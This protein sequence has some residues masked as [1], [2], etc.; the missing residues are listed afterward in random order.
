MAIDAVSTGIGLFG[1][2]GADHAAGAAADDGCPECVSFADVLGAALAEMADDVVFADADD[3]LSDD[4]PVAA[5]MDTEW[6][7]APVDADPAVGAAAVGVDAAAATPKGGYDLD[8][9]FEAAAKKYNISAK[10]LKAVAK[11]E[12]NFRPDATSRKGAMGIMQLMPG[13]AAGLG[14][15]DGYDPEQNIMGGAQYLRIQLNRFNGDVRLALGAYNAG[16]G[17]VKRAGGVP[18]YSENYVN[19][20]LG[21]MGGGD[22]SAGS[23]LYNRL[24]GLMRDEGKADSGASGSSGEGLAAMFGGSMAQTLLMYIIQMQMKSS[25]DDE[26]RVF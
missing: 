5:L 1:F 23:V 11:V 18:S 25:E 13:T 16:P 26:K 22:M 20:V 8:A 12:S 15:T 9:I 6:A 17:A 2:H 19:K 4:E 24:G 14:V 21:Y 7:Y 3:V 10:L